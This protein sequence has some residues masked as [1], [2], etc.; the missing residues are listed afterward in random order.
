MDFAK[1][2]HR[3]VFLKPM[4]A[5]TNSMNEDVIGWYPYHPVTNEY[6]DGMY[7]T[8]NNEFVKTGSEH[9]KNFAF[10]QDFEMWA[11]VS[12]MTG[13]EYAEAQKIRAETTYNITTRYMKNIESNMKILYG[14]KIFDIVSVLNIGGKNEE[15]KIVAAEVDR[16]GKG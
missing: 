11:C 4:N 8:N 15:L 3:I 1:M 7:V 10:G 16:Y 5:G 6:F 14:T 12:P 9:L 2:R 13:K